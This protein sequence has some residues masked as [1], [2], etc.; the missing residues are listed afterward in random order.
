[1][2]AL[3][4]YDAVNAYKSLY[5]P[6]LESSVGLA[7][8]IAADITLLPT[9]DIVQFRT[10]RDPGFY[11]YLYMMQKHVLILRLV[12]KTTTCPV[13]AY[14]AWTRGPPEFVYTRNI[15]SEILIYRAFR[16]ADF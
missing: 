6:G 9:S 11:E 7:L 5:S 15:H 14:E 2:V 4:A 8:Q 10:P 12:N 16:F 13:I 3:K 1:M